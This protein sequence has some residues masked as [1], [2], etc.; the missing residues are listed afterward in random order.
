MSQLPPGLR[1][2]VLAS[3]AGSPAAPQGSFWRRLAAAL[4][5]LISWSAAWLVFL[6][7]RDNWGA[8]PLWYRAAS[9]ALTGGTGLLLLLLAFQRGRYMV[10]P[11]AGQ[12]RL[13]SISLPLLSLA[14]VAFLAYPTRPELSFAEELMGSL[15]CHAISIAVA[16]PLVG[17]LSW[18]RRGLVLPAPGLL[19]ACLGASAAAW[20]HVVLFAT[21]PLGGATHA[22]F[23]HALPALPV[24]LLGAL[25][26]RRVFR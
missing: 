15:H 24:M 2:R 8:L 7:M 1:D 14:W 20:A 17:G 26:G 25:I 23:G 22:S 21:C 3:R 19:G 11:P 12:A 10:G 4:V 9:L 13:L 6:R 18:L 5:L 16:L